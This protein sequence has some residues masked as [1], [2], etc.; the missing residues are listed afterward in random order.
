MA[1]GITLDELEDEIAGGSMRDLTDEAVR[2][3]AERK[4][5][6]IR[7]AGNKIRKALGLPTEYSGKP[8]KGLGKR[9]R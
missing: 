9:R 8:P 1:S 4:L 6:S 5:Y 3:G 7:E 2:W